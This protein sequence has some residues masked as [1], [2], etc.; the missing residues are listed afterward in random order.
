MRKGTTGRVRVLRT[1]KVRT[2]YVK[3]GAS[4]TYPADT[5][6]FVAKKV[7][8]WSTEDLQVYGGRAI[9]GAK[10]EKP[11]E[12]PYAIGKSLRGML[13][14]EADATDPDTGQEL[15]L[16]ILNRAWSRSKLRCSGNGG[17]EQDED[18][19]ATCR[20]EAYMTAI[21]RATK[22][23]PRE[24]SAGK[25]L[26]VC[27]GSRC[28][29]WHTNKS[30]NAAAGCHGEL[31]LRFILLHPTTNPSDPNYL[32]QMGWAEI[33]SG[34]INA[35]W[36]I[37]SGFAA[38]RA[39]VNRTALI[40]FFLKRVPRTL[41]PEGKRVV[42]STLM[43]D[44]DHDEVVRFGYSDPKLSLVRPEI[45]KQLLEQRRELVELA[46]MEADFD[47]FRDIVPRLE[48][49]R[50]GLPA[51]AVPTAGPADE[52]SADQVVHDRDDVV[53]EARE[54]ASEAASS[55]VQ[56][57]E[58]ELNRFL[59]QSER[60]ELKT[61][62]GA[63]LVDGSFEPATLGRIRELVRR[64]Y[65]HFQDEQRGFNGLRVRHSQWI[66]EHLADELEAS[67]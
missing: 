33:A 30:T 8:G 23:K 61:L 2:G 56:L 65:V 12:E 51:P 11:D 63:K 43:V 27:R 14:F 57:S 3:A 62:A 40:P 39:L 6:V 5:D 64:A 28:P 31:R 4:S 13:P 26:V 25:W 58:A 53:D 18:G 19:E 60:N 45:R 49:A 15:T 16:E 55:P 67:A 34:S 37:Q 9:S 22:T 48:G 1:K 41:L 46:R 17:D 10:F 47:S 52:A 35:M 42:K 24:V 66:R 7:D 38:I 59:D 44:Y 50:P 21:T 36:D 54:T 32:K 29:M 20:D